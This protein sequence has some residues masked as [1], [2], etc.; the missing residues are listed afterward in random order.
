M[1]T[2]FGGKHLII[3]A[4]CAVVM[5][6]GFL[7]ARKKNMDQLARIL[8]A[9]GLISEIIKVFYYTMANALSGNSEGFMEKG[10]YTLE[11]SLAL[12]LGIILVT[13]CVRRIK[14]QIK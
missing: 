5:A 8:L 9:V 3:L 2:M 1:H 7:F 10:I 4:I 14:Y 6:A 13:S 12:A 11:L